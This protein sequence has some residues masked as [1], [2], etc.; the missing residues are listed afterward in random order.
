[1]AK[2]KG[3]SPKVTVFTPAVPL[4]AVAAALDENGEAFSMYV[5]V[6]AVQVTFGDGGPVYDPVILAA[7]GITTLTAFRA[8]PDT[9][10]AVVPLNWHPDADQPG[11]ADVARDLERQVTRP[12]AGGVQ[13]RTNDTVLLRPA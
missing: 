9:A 8:R 10:A 12:A 13:V 6:V 11:L 5:P 1:M 7:D 4:L 3:K 2:G